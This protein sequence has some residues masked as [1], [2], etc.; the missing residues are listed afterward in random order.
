MRDPRLFA[1]RF[2]PEEV[3][4]NGDFLLFVQLNR[5]GFELLSSHRLTQD[6]ALTSDGFYRLFASRDFTAMRTRFDWFLRKYLSDS[7]TK[8]SSDPEL[9]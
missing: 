2:L 1:S 3:F 7:F 6:A 9:F 5:S 4:Y 8:L